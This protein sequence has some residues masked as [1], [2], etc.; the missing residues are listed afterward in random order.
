MD[1]P[2][3]SEVKDLINPKNSN[4]ETKVLLSINRFERKKNLSLAIKTFSKVLDSKYLNYSKKSDEDSPMT[5]IVLIVAGG[6][7]PN[8]PENVDHLGEL[9]ETTK[10]EN[11]QYQILWPSSYSNNKYPRSSSNE[12]S[13]GLVLFLPSFSDNVRSYLFKI[14]S[15]ALYTPENEHFGLVPVESMYMSVPVIAVRSGGPKETIVDGK[16]GFLCKSTPEEFSIAVLQVLD[17]GPKKYSKDAILSPKEMRLEAHNH[18]KARFSLD[19]FSTQLQE[20]VY[21]ALESGNQLP[22]VFPIIVLLTSMF[23]VIVVYYNSV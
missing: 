2:E 4:S 21:E 18:A 19:T 23:I 8:L 10:E 16:T 1:D 7:D 3:I 9:I 20:C 5:N 6:Y 17:I 13:K 22:I 15:V 12:K 11:L 14:A